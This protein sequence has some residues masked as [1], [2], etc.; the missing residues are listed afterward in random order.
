MTS[1]YNYQPWLPDKEEEEECETVC[2]CASMS[3]F[4]QQGVCGPAVDNAPTHFGLFSSVAVVT[5]DGI[6]AA[7]CLHKQTFNYF[8]WLHLRTGSQVHCSKVRAAGIIHHL[9]RWDTER[10]EASSSSF[11][12]NNQN[13]VWSDERWSAHVFSVFW[14]SGCRFPMHRLTLLDWPQWGRSI[15]LWKRSTD[16]FPVVF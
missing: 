3:Y 9:Q 8:K 4:H 1:C 7:A 15:P 10:E 2:A 13:P 11:L 5:V 14:I 16:K 12:C 6:Q